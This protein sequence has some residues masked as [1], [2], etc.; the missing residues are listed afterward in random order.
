MKIG[1]LKK[2]EDLMVS[3]TFAENNQQEYALWLLNPDG[4]RKNQQSPR[5]NLNRQ[6]ENRSQMRL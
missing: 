1:L 3:V 5:K 6:P 2:L 4:N